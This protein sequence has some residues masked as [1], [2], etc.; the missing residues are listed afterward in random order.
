MAITENW[1]NIV[2]LKLLLTKENFLNQII[3]AGLIYLSFVF[4]PLNSPKKHKGHVHLL[5][6]KF[7]M[8]E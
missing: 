1:G 3:E 2:Y 4:L 6:E 8:L 7:G 5:P